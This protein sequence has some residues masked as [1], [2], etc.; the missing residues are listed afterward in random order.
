MN[1]EWTPT[2]RPPRLGGNKRMGVFATRSPYRPNPIGLSSVRLI[3]LRQTENEGTVLY[4]GGADL[5]SGTP[6]YDIKPYIPYTDIHADAKGG[7]AEEKL[8]YRLRVEMSE[9]LENFLPERLRA[10]A[11]EILAQDPRPAYHDDKNRIYGV[12]LADYD[13]RFCV[14][15]DKLTVTEIVVI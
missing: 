9:E 7:F 5:L 12:R 15:G 3:E 13:I 6:I 14:D 10:A 8:S 2:V 1:K 4:D 11:R